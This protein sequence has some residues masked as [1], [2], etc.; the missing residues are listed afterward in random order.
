M[1]YEIV[2]PK[3][4]FP[5]QVEEG[6]KV[7]IHQLH[8]RAEKWLVAH[9]YV[10]VTRCGTAKAALAVNLA[11][12]TL[13]TLLY[14]KIQSWVASVLAED[15]GNEYSKIEPLQ[16]STRGFNERVSSLVR[17]GEESPSNLP[18]GHLWWCSFENTAEVPDDDDDDGA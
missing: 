3:N 5:W 11:H 13:N 10:V 15:Y 2:L 16:I 1:S 4:R 14:D 6:A 12:K 8:Y 7:H 9:L 17:F 18:D